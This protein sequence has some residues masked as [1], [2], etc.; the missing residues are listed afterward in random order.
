MKNNFQKVMV[1]GLAS[2]VCAGGMSIATLPNYTD[3]SSADTVYAA[4]IKDTAMTATGTVKSNVFLRK[5]PG[6]SYGKIT[7]LTKG[8]KVDIVAKSSNGWYKIKYKNSYGYTYSSY[9]TVKDSDITTTETAY[10]ATGTTTTNLNVRK[11]ASA[12][13]KQLGALGK[14]A[15]VDIVAKVSN[16]WY[17]IKYNGGYGYVSGTYVKVGS[18]TETPS[19]TE[20]AYTATGT[21]KVNLNVRKGA[22]ASYT[23]LGS[24]KKGAKVDIVAKTNDGWYKIKYNKGYGYVSAQYVTVKSSGTETPSTPTETAYTATGTTKANLRVRK[25]NSTSSATLTTLKKGAK[26]DIVAK[27]NDG[28]YKIKYNKG[29]GYVSAQ[30]VTVKSTGTE[31]PS[32]P[33]VKYPADVVANHA[34]YI[35]SAASVKNSKVLGQI[36]KGEKATALE[37]TSQYWY[38]VQFTTKDGKV[39]VGYASS[40]Y[41]DIK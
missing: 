5:G 17:K 22:G 27:T 11:A 1:T 19:T 6:T 9:I 15:K 37:K 26:V 14:G 39:L 35:R 8:S 20:T 28:W 30:Y 13:S 18:T 38:K 29:Y 16:G 41:L 24:L 36:N 33:E 21:T 23:K 4:T 40:Q 32:T 31:T 34:V 12:S 2:I 3:L 25:S 7:V 10:T